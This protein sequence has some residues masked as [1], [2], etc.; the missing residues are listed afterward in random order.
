M[1]SRYSGAQRILLDD[2]LSVDEQGQLLAGLEYQINEAILGYDFRV[3]T[4]DPHK[5]FGL[6]VLLTLST[7]VK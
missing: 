5:K 6:M 2:L 3:M 1:S 7:T 4:K